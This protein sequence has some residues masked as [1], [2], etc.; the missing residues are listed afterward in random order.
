RRGPLARYTW[1]AC[2]PKKSYSRSL[3]AG[4]P[5]HIFPDIAHELRLQLLSAALTANV[6][7]SLPLGNVLIP[8]T[9]V[10]HRDVKLPKRSPH[11]PPAVGLVLQYATVRAGT[12]I[13]RVR[14][15]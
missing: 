11:Q 14:I 13:E 4:S 12:A 3:L 1:D 5:Q 10:Q 9:Q 2:W 8:G 7:G 6:Q 15:G